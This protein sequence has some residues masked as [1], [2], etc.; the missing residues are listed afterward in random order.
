MVGILNM[1]ISKREFNEYKRW[2]ENTQNEDLQEHMANQMIQQL[3]HLRKQ[4]GKCDQRSL[5]LTKGKYKGSCVWNTPKNA[6]EIELRYNT[7][8]FRYGY[9]SN[10]YAAEHELQRLF[11]EKENKILD[12]LQKQREYYKIQNRLTKHPKLTDNTLNISYIYKDKNLRL[13]FHKP[14]VNP[15]T[16]KQQKTIHWGKL[17]FKYFDKKH[18]I[19]ECVR[20]DDP[21]EIIKYREQLKQILKEQKQKEKQQ[22]EKRVE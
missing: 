5:L 1:N 22:K 11:E 8:K 13:H 21:V 17:W 12:T 19:K 6:Y 14:F 3:K 15:I 7:H 4:D 16:S 9:F 18:L 2:V 20:L 10:L